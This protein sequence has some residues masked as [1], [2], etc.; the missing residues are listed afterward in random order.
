MPLASRA[1]AGMR[2]FSP[3]APTY[4]RLVRVGVQ[5]G[6]ADVAAE[7]RADDHRH[8]EAALGAEAHPGDLTLDL[9]ERLAAEPEELELGHRH[10]PAAG[11]P[12]RRADDD[13]LRER[14]VDDAVVAEAGLQPVG[15]AE[16]AAVDADVLAEQDDTRSSRSSSAPRL[17]RIAS[18]IVMTAISAS[19][20][21]AA[22]ALPAQTAGR[23]G[24]HVV[25]ERGGTRGGGRLGRREGGVDLRAQL[26][27]QALPRQPRRRRPRASRWR[28]TRA[29]GSLARRS[30][31]S[32]GSTYRVG[33]SEVLC[34]P[35]R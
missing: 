12:D 7:R 24:V 5:L 30:S 18:T 11:Q 33:S 1:V 27:G 2:T 10:E 23:V 28:R 9:V 29:I 34:G 4:L 13:R 8:A 25:E 17:A 14:H 20:P 32:A 16:D 31:S 22:G 21:V 35:I 6:R 3:G 26:V 19:S 15:G